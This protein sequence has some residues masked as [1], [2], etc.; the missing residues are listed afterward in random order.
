MKRTVY[1]DHNASTPLD[2]R[3]L[4]IMCS[5]LERYSANPS[6][7][8][9]PGQEARLALERAREQTASLLNARP[10]QI[11]FTGSGTESINIAI[12]GAL[13]ACDNKT[14]RHLI[15]SSIEHPAVRNTAL[16]C[17]EGG[18]D[19]DFLPVDSS[20]FVSCDQLEQLITEHTRLVS[21]MCANNETGAVQDLERISD[22]CRRRRIPFH[23]DAVQGFGKLDLSPEKTGFDLLSA[24][25]HKIYGPKGVGLLYF[26]NRGLLFPLLR[27][28][29]QENGLRPGTEALAGI[30]GFVEALRIMCEKKSEENARLSDFTSFLRREIKFRIPDVAFNTP[31]IRCLP[32][33]LSISV[34]LVDGESLLTELD[35]NGICV[36]SGSACSSGDPQPSRVLKAMGLS[37]E[38]ATG[39]LRLSL[40]RTTTKEE[41]EFFLHILTGAVSRLRRMH[42]LET[43]A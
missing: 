11:I 1:L 12:Q 17:S 40:G 36:S 7:I 14:Q 22:V 30:L 2:R 39:S 38:K 18:T 34:P 29:G 31:E 16:A 10:D 15:V 32:G 41:L 19:L 24:S 8:H 5:A 4:D 26:R 6:S 20:G 23:T 3:V 9:S 25:A 37:D 42:P 13:L 43:P 28:G 21:V 27:G 35:M 33:T